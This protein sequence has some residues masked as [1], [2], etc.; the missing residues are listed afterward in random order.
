MR[1]ELLMRRNAPAEVTK[2]TGKTHVA[3]IIGKQLS[4]AQ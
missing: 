3:G 2:V 4:R 1:E